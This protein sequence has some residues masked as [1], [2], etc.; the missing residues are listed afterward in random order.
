MIADIL[1][2][3]DDVSASD[4]DRSID[5]VMDKLETAFQDISEFC[6]SR[7]MTVNAA[8]T[9]FIII[10]ASTKRLPDDVSI[11]LDDAVIPASSAVKLL[12]VTIDSHLTFGEHIVGTVSR[13]HGLLGLLH[14]AAPSLTRD[15]LR[16]AYMALVRTH[17]EYCSTLLISV[18][19]CHTTKLE[20]VQK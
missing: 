16:L 8:K 4:H 13:C 1:Q 9:Q 19:S 11:T 7:D 6:S 3:A 15:L 18:S 2:F 20:V 10:K 17:L 14:R 12:G 5:V